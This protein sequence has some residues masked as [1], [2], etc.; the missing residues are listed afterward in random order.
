MEGESWRVTRGG[1]TLGGPSTN[2]GAWYSRVAS[3]SECSW[4]SSRNRYDTRESD[5][6]RS[7]VG[8][9]AS[10]NSS[11]DPPLFTH[12]SGPSSLNAMRWTRLRKAPGTQNDPPGRLGSGFGV[13]GAYNSGVRGGVLRRRSI[14][15]G[16][17]HSKGKW[18]AKRGGDGRHT[19][20]ASAA[21]SLAVASLVTALGMPRH[22]ALRAICPSR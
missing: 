17:G 9:R 6:N 22:A 20:A 13:W 15:H 21:V 2:F 11:V 3:Q 10:Y 12:H 16:G 1:S 19:T 8:G 14:R 18:Y 5:E 4:Y 7:N